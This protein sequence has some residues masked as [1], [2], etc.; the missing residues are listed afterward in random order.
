M[1]PTIEQTS[2]C[3]AAGCDAR[4]FWHPGLVIF[5]SDDKPIDPPVI[6]R[7]SVCDKHKARDYLRDIL[8]G[9]DAQS[10]LFFFSEQ[11]LLEEGLTALMI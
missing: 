11:Y 2:T 3:H 10:V 6:F 7:Q 8:D 5:T 9:K 4:G 1:S